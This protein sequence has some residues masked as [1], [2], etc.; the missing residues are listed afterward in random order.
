MN[1]GVLTVLGASVVLL[2]QLLLQLIEACWQLR[3]HV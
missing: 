1:S 3:Q 2:L